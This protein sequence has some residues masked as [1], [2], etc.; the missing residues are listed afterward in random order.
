MTGRMVVLQSSFDTGY[1]LV[2][3][4][5]K[6]PYRLQ[7]SYSLQLA[8][9]QP[10]VWTYNPTPRTPRLTL[11][12][13]CSCHTFRRLQCTTPPVAAKMKSNGDGWHWFLEVTL[14]CRT[15]RSAH[16]YLMLLVF[17]LVSTLPH[18]V[19]R[20]LIAL[21]MEAARTCETLAHFYQTT[22]RNNPEDSHLHFCKV[23][24]RG[25]Y[26]KD[27]RGSD[28]FSIYL[29]SQV[30][31]RK[32]AIRTGLWNRP[33]GPCS[34]NYPLSRRLVSSQLIP[35]WINSRFPYWA[36][37]NKLFPWSSCKPRRVPLP[38]SS[39]RDKFRARRRAVRHLRRHPTEADVIIFKCFRSRA[40]RN[41]GHSFRHSWENFLFSVKLRDLLCYVGA[42]TANIRQI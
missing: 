22:R 39:T 8:N 32:S 7:F 21:M 36:V 10:A 38:W 34:Y 19:L 4:R 14:W 42:S 18:A 25:G 15:R 40:Q 16:T 13:P 1:V 37:L 6:L 20:S 23:C 24:S 17:S 28:H 11:P 5:Y 2:W 33:Y 35:W 30:S 3:F 9:L 27:L 29:C 41:V 26:F 31:F 12:A